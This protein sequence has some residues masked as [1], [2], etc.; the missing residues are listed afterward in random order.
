M[1][2][3]IC[4]VRRY[5]RALSELVYA[6]DC[7]LILSQ[8]SMMRQSELKLEK[9]V[10]SLLV[11]GDGRVQETRGVRGASICSHTLMG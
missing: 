10:Y 3:S 4:Y 8:S 9:A 2:T 6:E 5:A 7:S 11:S 1:C